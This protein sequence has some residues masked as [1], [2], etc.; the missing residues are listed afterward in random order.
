MI[1]KP[2]LVALSVPLW[3]AGCAV[4]APP[5]ATATIAS[6]AQWQA[7]LP[8]QGRLADLGQWWQRFDDPLLITLITAAQQVSPTLASAAARIEQAR[9]TQRLIGAGSRPQVEAAGSTSRGRQTTLIG[10]PL[11]MLSQASLQASWETDLFGGIAASRD[12]AQARVQGAQAQWHEARVS[13]AAELAN[14]YF[15]WRSCLALVALARSDSDSRHTSERMARL[16]A[17]AGLATPASAALARASAAEGAGRLT[18]QQAQCDTEVKAMVAMTALD[19]ADLRQKLLSAPV[20]TAQAAP[21]SIAYIPAQALQQRPD[22]YQA[23]RQVAAASAEVGSAQAERYPRLT[24]SGSIGQ[25]NVR[26]GGA[27]TDIT[28]WSMGPL[29]ISLPILDGGKSAANLAAA[30]ARYAEAVAVYQA[31][32]RQA[33]RE[34]E[35]ALV[36]LDSINARRADVQAAAQSYLAVFEASDLRYKAGLASLAEREDA[37]RSLLAAQTLHIGLQRDAL[38]AWVALYRA[39]GGG[40][41]P[42]ANPDCASDRCKP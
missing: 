5:S 10:A 12:A 30:N 13:V 21:F 27:S 15:G 19:E 37:R 33:V 8:H 14:H 3:L 42:E 6:P 40:W 9:S 32:A 18:Q 36:N 11:A 16:T 28:T 38:N 4:P 41:T 1:P 39:V 23:D 2:F 35:E 29:A 24:L 26:S 34:V 22:L 7:P 31:R 20:G 25:L 17:Q